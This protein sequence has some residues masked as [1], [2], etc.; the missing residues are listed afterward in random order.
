MFRRRS[1]RS[2]SSSWNR[3]SRRDL[4][5]IP[6][7]RYWFLDDN[8]QRNVSLL[9]TGQDNATVANVATEL[10][11]QMRRF[12]MVANVVSGKAN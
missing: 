12:P 10:A 7:I 5:D 8:G 4:A 6:D 3:K 1:G 2:R 11:G 9:V